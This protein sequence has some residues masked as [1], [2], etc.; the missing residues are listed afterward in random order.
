MRVPTAPYCSGAPWFASGMR[1]SQYEPCPGMPCE[2]RGSYLRDPVAQLSRPE[3][4]AEDALVEALTHLEQLRG[5][6]ARE[7]TQRSRPIYS[8]AR[9][10]L[11]KFGPGQ[12]HDHSRSVDFARLDGMT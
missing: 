8:S 10:D 4:E 2:V 11:H 3:V 7:R 6:R 12:P 1:G 5:R 9:P